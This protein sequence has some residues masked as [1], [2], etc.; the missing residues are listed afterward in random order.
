METGHAISHFQAEA[1]TDARIVRE[2]RIMS[3]IE[4]ITEEQSNRHWEMSRR[5]DGR[6]ENMAYDCEEEEEDTDRKDVEMGD[7]R[8]QP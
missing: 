8:A 3:W 7:V 4:P 5:V 2:E 1:K 6:T